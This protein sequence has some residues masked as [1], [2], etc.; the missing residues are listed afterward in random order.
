MKKPI[1]F[2]S[3]ESFRNR[4]T[5]MTATKSD[6]LLLFGLLIAILMELKMLY[7]RFWI[8]LEFSCELT[9]KYDSLKSD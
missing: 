7:R 2:K 8:Q 6:S 9:P 1:F 3:L 5:E 4:S